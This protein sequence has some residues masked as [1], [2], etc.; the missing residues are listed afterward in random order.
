MDL[1]EK[2]ELKLMWSFYLE[3]FLCNILFLY[4]IFGILYFLD[5]GFSLTQIGII[6][7]ML[8]LAIILFEIPTGAIADIYGRKFSVILGYL[9]MGITWICVGF[10]SNFYLICGFV[11]LSGLFYTLTSGS[12]SAW[13]VDLLKVNKQG[14]KVHDLNSI[15]TAIA[16]AGVIIC[17]II[18]SIV[19][20]RFGL[21]ITWPF[22]GGGFLISAL[23]LTFA[24]EDFVRKKFYWKQAL[25]KVFNQMNDSVK[26]VYKNNNI[27]YLILAGAFMCIG[28]C[29][30][31][32][33]SFYPL[34]KE[35]GLPV[36][37][38]GYLISVCFSIG[39]LV[40]LANK[41]LIDKFGGSKKYLVGL[42]VLLVLFTLPII[43]IN[44]LY[45]Y[46]TL[47]VI[48]WFLFIFYGT[49][50]FSFFQSY[51]P[52]KKRA[53]IDSIRS[54][55]YSLIGVLVLPLAGYT[56]DTLGS[57]VAIFIGAIFYIPA[58]IIYLK[59]KK[60]KD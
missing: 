18:G 45:G 13:F 26:E 37:Y 52:S 31:S 38:F 47:F 14:K 7:A 9:L 22:T 55:A 27:F 32:D 21:W 24:K 4:P 58:I 30:T 60:K 53:T 3:V 35:A 56:V 11:F 20:G 6:M 1:I 19:V 59:V 42:L 5:I 34:I 23:V 57:K 17:G 10:V 15:Q 40:P 16:S 12:Y 54:M 36:N 44:N 8:N 39:L 49:I 48:G 25:N 29:F 43:F 28:I 33:I 46:I 50:R 51:L 2:Y 41:K